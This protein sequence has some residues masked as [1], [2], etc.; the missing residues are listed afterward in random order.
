MTKTACSTRRG[1][2]ADGSATRRAG[3]CLARLVCRGEQRDGSG[4]CVFARTQDVTRRRNARNARLSTKTGT[5]H[6]QGYNIWTSAADHQREKCTALAL[7][8]TPGSMQPRRVCVEGKVCR[9]A[10]P[11]LRPAWRPTTP[12]VRLAATMLGVEP[13]EPRNFHRD[14][15]RNP[16]ARGRR[17]RR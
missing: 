13:T 3:I 5:Q 6:Q 2:D 7:V 15:G 10:D 1:K 8:K 9:C 14:C 4:S 16:R 11:P 17:T 12:D